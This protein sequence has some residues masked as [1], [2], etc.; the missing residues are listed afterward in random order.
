MHTAEGRDITAV[1]AV[2][3]GSLHEAVVKM[4]ILCF[5]QVLK[6][7]K[8]TKVD[9]IYRGFQ[10]ATLPTSFFTANDANVKGGIEVRSTAAGRRA[11]SSCR[12]RPAA[13][14]PP[15]TGHTAR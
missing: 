9:T 4:A 5:Q 11:R 13:R 15:P 7:S 6:L 8:L 2:V 12:A 3:S 14:D 1:G 10:G